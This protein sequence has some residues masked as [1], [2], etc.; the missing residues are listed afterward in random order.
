M[1]GEGGAGGD[2]GGGGESSEGGGG[3]V[4]VGWHKLRAAGAT[5]HMQPGHTLLRTVPQRSQTGMRPPQTSHQGKRCRPFSDTV[6]PGRSKGASSGSA[7]SAGKPGDSAEGGG[8]GAAT[9][10]RDSLR[11]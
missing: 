8:G 3:G 5:L 4:A 6:Q 9:R 1:G 2:G 11:W 10:P 7:E